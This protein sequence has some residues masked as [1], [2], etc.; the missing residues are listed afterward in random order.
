MALNA[1]TP[2]IA[3]PGPWTPPEGVTNHAGGPVAP[4]ALFFEPPPPEIGTPVSAHSTVTATK[5]GRTK[6]F[7]LGLALFTGALVGVTAD[8]AYE[9]VFTDQA[10]TAMIGWPWLAAGVIIGALTFVLTASHP[11]VTYAGTHGVAK[12]RRRGGLGGAPEAD[13]FPFSE[14]SELRTSQTRQYYNGV[15]TGTAYHFTWSNFAGGTRFRLHGSYRDKSGWPKDKDPFHFALA[16]EHAWTNHLASQIQTELQGQGHVQFNLIKNQWIRL[17]P[18]FI[19]IFL[20]KEAER[21]TV[22]DIK[23]LTVNSGTFIIRDREAKRFSRQGVFK[24]SYA[25]LANAKLFLIALDH[26]LGYRFENPP[27]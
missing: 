9:R 12:I 6:G 17:G 26:F 7:R 25:N 4:D 23:E 24:F 14:A 18:G 11:T 22:D 19:E 1:P 21:L 15:Y 2:L 27:S 10:P 13:I 8:W 3:A 20:G 16:A 5:T